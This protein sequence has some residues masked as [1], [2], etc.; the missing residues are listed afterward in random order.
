MRWS[1]RRWCRHAAT[2][3]SGFARGAPMDFIDSPL[4]RLQDAV[5]RCMVPSAT[6]SDVRQLK[7]QIELRQRVLRDIE[8][9]RR[10]LSL[11]LRHRGEGP[12]RR[13]QH[14][15]RGASL[16]GPSGPRLANSSSLI[17]G[18]DRRGQSEQ[19]TARFLS[20]NYRESTG[21]IIFPWNVWAIPLILDQGYRIALSSGNMGNRRRRHDSEEDGF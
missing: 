13:A 15:R 10:R 14:R 8:V 6:S 9:I 21:I 4:C 17:A 5:G 19:R 3:V 16:A 12:R 7:A 2:V 11:F 20:P 18:F 1:R